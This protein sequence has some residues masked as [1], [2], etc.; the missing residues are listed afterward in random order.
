MNKPKEMEENREVATEFLE[1]LEKVPDKRKGEALG[2][3]KGYALCAG[4]E[5]KGA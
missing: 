1:I 5:P 3:L 4:S 2:I